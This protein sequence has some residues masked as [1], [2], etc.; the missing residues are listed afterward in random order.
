MSDFAEKPAP[1]VIALLEPRLTGEMSVEEAVRARRS[2]RGFTT[3]PVSI[4][5]VSQVLWAAQGITDAEGRRAA[6]SAGALYA[7]D[8]YVVA[9]GQEAGG[10]AAGVYHYDPRRHSLELTMAGDARPTL[11]RLAVGQTF[12]ADAPFALVITAEYERISG[13][14]GNRAERYV[15]MEAGHAAQNVYLQVEA[16]GLGTVVVGSFQDE[17][18]SQALSLPARHMPLYI[19]PIG[20]TV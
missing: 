17:A 4:E 16:L 7:L 3:S 11:A 5:Q 9:G 19:M 2:R 1:S 14:Y 18:V 6:P 12:I 15:H 20:D 13:R 10:L 8:L